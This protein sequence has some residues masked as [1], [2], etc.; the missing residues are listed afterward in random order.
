MQGPECKTQRRLHD[1]SWVPQHRLQPRQL[2]SEEQCR[3]MRVA[4]FYIV[5]V[6]LDEA[7]EGEIR[8]VPHTET[9]RTSIASCLTAMGNATWNTSKRSE[10]KSKDVPC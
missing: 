1:L 5:V 10:I 9:C 3:K 7:L 8:Q 6:S 2:H 4:I